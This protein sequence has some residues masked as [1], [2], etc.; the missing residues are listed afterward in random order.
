[1]SVIDG[2]FKGFSSDEDSPRIK[3][4]SRAT[5]PKPIILKQ[6]SAELFDESKAEQNLFESYRRKNLFSNHEKGFLTQDEIRYEQ[7]P[8][9]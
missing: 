7:E 5:T 2:G 3:K 6:E 8:T 9:S 4:S 1:M